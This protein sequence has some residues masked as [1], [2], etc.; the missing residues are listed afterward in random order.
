VKITYNVRNVSSSPQSIGLRI[1]L[2]TA[3]SDSDGVSFQVPGHGL[4][5]S[6]YAFF[7]EDVPL[8]WYSFD[9][10]DRPKVRSIGVVRGGDYLSP[11]RLI[12]AAW[13]RI[14]GTGTWNFKAEQG[15]SFRSSI[16]SRKD[17]AVALE[18][19]CRTLAAGGGDFTVSTA[20]G[21]YGEKELPAAESLVSVLMPADTV[22]ERKDLGT[23]FFNELAYQV[24]APEV[25]ISEI[26]EVVLPPRVVAVDE[27]PNL[28]GVKVLPPLEFHLP[29]DDGTPGHAAR[30][31]ER[32]ALV[33]R[34]IE[35][36]LRAFSIEK[37]MVVDEFWY[38]MTML[39]RFAQDL[40][41][42]E[43]SLPIIAANVRE[44][45]GF[46]GSIAGR[47]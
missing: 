34:L 44:L 45:E 3:L 5:N 38:I 9:N 24:G 2:D 1:V 4:I 11:D 30:D 31:A 6:E 22:E 8:S 40:R 29:G 36:R 28:S 42:P 26:V 25:A 19:A 47:L 23:D 32:R 39:E 14:S 7:G 18:Y 13:R 27:Q 37:E 46:L 35:I 20:Y 43:S 12:F 16:F 21:L 33:A 41:Y 10:Y 15:R 17:S